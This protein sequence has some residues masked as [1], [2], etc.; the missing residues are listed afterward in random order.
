MLNVAEN[1]D[2]L[3]QNSFGS[4]IISKIL[5]EINAMYSSKSVYTD[6]CYCDGGYNDSSHSD[7]HSDCYSDKR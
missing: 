5:K 4:N 7:C 2:L 6:S 3:N 1:K